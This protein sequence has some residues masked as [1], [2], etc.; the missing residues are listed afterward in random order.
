MLRS[1]PTLHYERR[2]RKSNPPSFVAE[3]PARFC[4]HVRRCRNRSDSRVNWNE[5]ARPRN[6]RAS[7]LSGRQCN[8]NPK[9]QSQGS[10]DYRHGVPQDNSLFPIRGCSV[11]VVLD[12]HLSHAKPSRLWPNGCGTHRESCSLRLALFTAG[13]PMRFQRSNSPAGQQTS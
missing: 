8:G 1:R 13:N 11:N 6:G 2:P 9:T 10:L 4:L 7:P 12:P 3:P 5:F